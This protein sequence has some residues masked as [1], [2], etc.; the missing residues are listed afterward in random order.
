MEGHLAV[1]YCQKSLGCPDQ[2]WCSFLYDT[3]Y[4]YGALVG[5]SNKQ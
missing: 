1:E 4:S 2:T 5:H 3:V